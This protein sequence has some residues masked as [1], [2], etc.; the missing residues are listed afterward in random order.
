MSLQD[1]GEM[2]PQ[3]E[4]KEEKHINGPKGTDIG[5]GHIDV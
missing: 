5:F 1:Q 2:L 4:S 3:S